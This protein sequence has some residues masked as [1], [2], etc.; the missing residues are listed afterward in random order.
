MRKAAASAA[1]HL[2][3]GGPAAPAAGAPPSDGALSLETPSGALATMGLAQ[4]FLALYCSRLP[5]VDG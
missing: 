3:V 5:G 1:Q 2:P 4:A